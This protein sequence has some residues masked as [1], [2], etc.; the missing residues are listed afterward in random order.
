MR[1]LSATLLAYQKKPT[2]RP[3]VRL[4]LTSGGTSYTYTKT[5]IWDIKHDEAPWSGKLEITLDNADKSLTALDLKGFNAVLSKGLTTSAGEEYSAAAPL[6]VIDQRFESRPGGLFCVLTCWGIPNLMAEDRASASYVPASSDTLTVQQLIT[7]VCG[8]TLAPFTHCA[9]YTVVYDSTDSLIGT[10][11]PKDGFRIYK[12]GSR[13]AAL[14]RLIEYTGCAIRWGADGQVHVFVPTTAGLVYDYEYSLASGYHT[15]FAKAYQKRLVIPNKVTV[16]SMTGDSPAYAGFATDA[17]SFALLPKQEFHQMR[18][19]SDAQATSIAQAIIGQAQLQAEGGSGSVPMNV[20][21]EVYDYVKITDARENDTRV[22]NI[23][24]IHSRYSVKNDQWEMT[25]GFGGWANFRQLLND[26]ETSGELG[27]SFARLY[28]KDAYIERLTAGSIDMTSVTLDTLGEGTTYK[29]V[30]ATQISAGKIL[31]SDQVLYNAG[32][33]PS[34]KRR[35]FTAT[36]TT[37]YDVG[38]IWMDGAVVK[39]CTIGRGSGAYQATDWA[40]ITQDMI[41]NGFSYGRLLLTDIQAGHIRLTSAAVFDGKW[42]SASGVS[43]NASS[44]INIWG[45]ANALTTRATEAGTIECYVGADGKIY[46]GAGAV[47]MDSSGLH[48]KGETIWLRHSDGVQKGTVGYASAYTALNIAA[49]SGVHIRLS[50]G[51]GGFI[52]ANGLLDLDYD[53]S[54]RLKLPVGTNQY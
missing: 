39:R 16:E 54:G 4:V 40:Q 32:Y 23:G 48:L 37:P 45:T 12:N 29:R 6:A 27:Q 33:N 30:L 19:A 47:Y 22:G 9:A 28:A 38:D 51:G 52:Y 18:L 10:F 2:L 26:L 17:A 5:R 1:T 49:V 50:V 3:L 14:R 24:Y 42:Y 31:L 34:E 36:P 35:N 11:Q 44:G 20:G 46:A 21:A 25:F 15:F 8:A 53:T 43:I 41:A 13:L 7:A